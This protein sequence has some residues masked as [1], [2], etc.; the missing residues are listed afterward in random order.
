MERVDSDKTK[1]IARSILPWVPNKKPTPPG[2]DMVSPNPP[3]PSAPAP[4]DS[5]SP[6]A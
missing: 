5:R 1:K 4:H 3:F 2:H 6:Q